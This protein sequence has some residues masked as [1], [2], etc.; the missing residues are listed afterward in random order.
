M[1]LRIWAGIVADP[2]HPEK[3]PFKNCEDG[4]EKMPK[5]SELVKKHQSGHMPKVCSY[6]IS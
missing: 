1:D 6:I 4:Q 2:K 3:T 5:L